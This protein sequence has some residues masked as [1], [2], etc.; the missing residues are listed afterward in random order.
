MQF[1]A[2]AAGFWRLNDHGV[3]YLAEYSIT[4][5][6]ESTHFLWVILNLL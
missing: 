1:N 6:P 5:I 4:R 3:A 2:I